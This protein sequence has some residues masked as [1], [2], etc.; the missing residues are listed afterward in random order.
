MKKILYILLLLSFIVSCSTKKTGITNRTYHRITS[1]YNTIFNGNVALEEDQ[2]SKREGYKDNFSVLLKVDPIDPFTESSEDLSLSTTYSNPSKKEFNP[3]GLLNGNN[4]NTVQSQ[5]Q[6]LDRVIEKGK[7]AIENHSMQVKGKEYNSMLAEAYLLL[8]KAS[9]YK[10]DPFEALNYLNYMNAAMVKNNKVNEGKVYIA[11]SHALAGNSF[12]ANEQFDKLLK[13]DLKKKDIKLLT[14]A[15]SQFLMDED[16]FKE[17]IAA[18]EVAKKYHKGKY[19]RGRYSF[20]QGQLSEKL[21]KE[22]SAAEYYQ[23][24][25]DKKP[26]PELEI[27]S[28]IALSRLFTGDSLA[29]KERMSFLKKLTRQ[30]L[31]Q[32]RK[33]ELYYAMGLVAAKQSREKQAMECFLQSL[34]ERE[35]DPQVRALTYQAV[36]DVYFSKPDYV[37]AG[38]YYDSAI[39]RFVD[40]SMKARLEVKNKALKD[41]TSKYYLVKKNDSIL[42][43]ANMT[44]EQRNE[45]YGKYIS[46]LKDQ[47]EKARIEMEKQMQRDNNVVFATETLADGSMGLVSGTPTTGGKWY[48]YNSNLKQSGQSEFRKLWGS[49]SLVDNWRMSKKISSL[50]EVKND[51]LGQKEVKNPRR[52]E[53]EFYTEKIPSSRVDLEKL[54]MERDTTELALGIL[55]YDK[56]RDLK[57]ANTSLEHLLSTPPMDESVA[58]SAMYNLY[59]YNKEINPEISRKYADL[60]VSKYP[61]SKYAESILNPDI[62]IFKSKSGTATRYYEE[63][64]KKYEQGKYSEVKEMSEQALKN[65]PTDEIIAKFSLLSVFCDGRMGNKQAFMDGLQRVATAFEN[66]EEGKKAAELLDFF[67][68]KEKENTSQPHNVNQRKDTNTLDPTDPDNVY[69]SYDPQGRRIENTNQQPSYI[70]RRNPGIPED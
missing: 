70:D 59:R 8:G 7:K 15:Y 21:K 46:K 35:S 69:K 32:S 41:L 11:L 52:F 62:D 64:Y 44:P 25:Y 10:K 39:S 16:R 27:K 14:K 68:K 31:Y 3:Y 4:Q 9:Y 49:R 28:Q 23:M 61:G 36:G 54:K 33:N 60:V 45:Y 53:V 58:L 66:R 30:G 48:F 1:W 19:E 56:L 20:I 5:A 50:D 47:E 12:E 29:Y 57:S 42:S 34:K 63:A 37:Y 55:Y 65:Y 2:K 40:P 67:T 24:A 51:L 6:G 18:L 26:S 13:E 38:A 17:G 43:V 22:K